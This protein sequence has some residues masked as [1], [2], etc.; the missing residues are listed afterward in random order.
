MI[1]FIELFVE[2]GHAIHFYKYIFLGMNE[3]MTRPYKCHYF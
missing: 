1:F 3:T 2:A